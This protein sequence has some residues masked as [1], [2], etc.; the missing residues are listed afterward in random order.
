MLTSQMN[1]RIGCPLF[2]SSQELGHY[3]PASKRP[4]VKGNFQTWELKAGP[5]RAAEAGGPP[6]G[7]L[8]RQRTVPPPSDS[9]L[10]GAAAGGLLAVF[11]MLTLLVCTRA[12]CRPQRR[13]QR[14]GGLSLTSPAPR[15]VRNA[16][17]SPPRGNRSSLE[18]E[19]RISSRTGSRK[20]G[21][22]G[23]SSDQGTRASGCR[24][25]G[26]GPR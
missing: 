8:G 23:L 16:G 5:G 22:C 24:F 9:A 6:R 11:C 25:G 18:T 3:V 4:E 19:F 26:S 20:K 10:T 1:E 2:N 14:S 17:T 15:W 21:S 13:S 7:S 12:F